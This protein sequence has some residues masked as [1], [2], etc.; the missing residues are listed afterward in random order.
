MDEESF[1]RRAIYGRRI[2]FQ[3]TELDAWFLARLILR[4]GRARRRQL[5]LL[6][7]AFLQEDETTTL[8]PDGE[9]YLVEP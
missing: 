5:L 4:L 6:V 1:D 9:D 3:R 7:E 8:A 2:L